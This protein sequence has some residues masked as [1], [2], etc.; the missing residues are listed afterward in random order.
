MQDYQVQTRAIQAVAESILK[1]VLRII[2]KY[3]LRYYILGGTLLGAVRHQGF[4]PWDDDIDLGMPRPDYE[5][6]LTLAR[7]ELSDPYQLQTFQDQ[8][9]TSESYYAQVAKTDTLVYKVYAGNEVK[10]NVWI[11]IFPLDGVP[12]RKLPFFVWKNKAMLLSKLFTLSQVEKE[13]DISRNEAS[14]FKTK[15]EKIITLYV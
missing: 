14:A 9:R 8:V 1:E 5:R 11:D 13:Y 7:Q 2:G 10:S 15:K 3:D 12:E 4:I 6:F